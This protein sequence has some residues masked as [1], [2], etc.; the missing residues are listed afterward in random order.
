MKVLHLS[1]VLDINNGGGVY[2]VVVN[3]YHAQKKKNLDVN[4]CYPGNCNTHPSF[5]SDNDVE[6]MQTIGNPN[7][8]LI[9]NKLSSKL[10]SSRYE[11]IHQHGIWLPNSLVT[12]KYAKKGI[13][14]F[15]QPHGFLER[16]SFN[17]S[18]YKKRFAFLLY[19]K[20]NIE[21]SK[22]LIA[23]SEKEAIRLKNIFPQKPV[24]IIPNGVSNE[25]YKGY[26]NKRPNSVYPN[27][28][29]MLFVSQIYPLKGL[30]RFFKVISEVEKQL[31]NNWVIVIAGYGQ[32]E[33]INFLEILIKKLRID[34]FIYFVGPKYNKDKIYLLD[35][36]DFFVF[37]TH[38]E[39][40]GIVVAEALAHELPVLTTTGTPWQELNTYQCGYQ[41]QN[42]S[43][44]LKSGLIKMLSLSDSQ[45][46]TMGHSGRGLINEKYLWEIIVD[47]TLSLYSWG[48][49]QISKPDFV[50]K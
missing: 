23:C 15:I 8:G 36:A 20:D 38:N 22:A 7:L 16:F 4:I 37:P 3:L 48:M 29:I 41:V 24:A 13:I 11:I 9:I 27:K 14:T 35:S 34:H 39:N 5:V 45:R 31:L 21:F 2:E 17:I 42:T 44:G 10:N 28:K 30:E 6:R 1:N 32:D 46:K 47:K 33:Y 49:G 25:F 19:E 26:N 40:F 12:L 50:L 18:K 43:S